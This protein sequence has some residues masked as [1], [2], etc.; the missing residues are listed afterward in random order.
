MDWL[1]RMKSAM[2]YIETNLA[3]NILY[4]DIAQ[5]ACCST[6]HFQRC[7]SFNMGYFPGAAM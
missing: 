3:D 1:E 6:Y 7:S 5:I 4:D 2:D